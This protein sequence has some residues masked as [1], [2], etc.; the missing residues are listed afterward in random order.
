MREVLKIIAAK[1]ITIIGVIVLIIIAV[2]LVVD[3]NSDKWEYV[4]YEEVTNN[5][6][7]NDFY[8]A[9]LEY[10]MEEEN[11]TQE[12]APEDNSIYNPVQNGEN[13]IVATEVYGKLKA[14][15]FVSKAEALAAVY[16][17]IEPVYGHKAAVGI[18]ANVW[19]E[20]NFGLVQFGHSVPDWNGDGISAKSS[21]N[22]PL[23]VSS[24]VNA[25]AIS[26][27]G[28]NK[29]NVTG[30]GIVQWT[31]Y[32]YMQPL[33]SYYKKYCNEG[34]NITGLAKAEMAMLMDCA[35]AHKNALNASICEDVCEQWLM[36]FE[37]PKNA[38][39]EIKTRRATATKLNEVLNG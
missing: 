19:H 3:Y 31:Y 9:Y 33:A 18:M 1:V 15:A 24:D 17:T 38:S 4:D 10:I 8:T 14:S 23:I 26:S 20:G 36:D 6:N 12:V 37:K 13:D 25:E 32:T 2:T 34:Y 16:E 21:I 35:A 5:Y 29:S 28:N 27:L 30:V 7:R 39:G 22:N 11:S